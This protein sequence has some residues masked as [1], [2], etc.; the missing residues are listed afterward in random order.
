M[1]AD[2]S[3]LSTRAARLYHLLMA[4]PDRKWTFADIADRFNTSPSGATMLVRSLA[5]AGLGD[6][7]DR[8]MGERFMYDPTERKARAAARRKRGNG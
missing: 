2:L 8:V 1:K 7:R 3:T 5:S 6:F 4:E